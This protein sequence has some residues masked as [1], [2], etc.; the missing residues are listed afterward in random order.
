MAALV[1][2]YR[3]RVAPLAAKVLG[4]TEGGLT[5]AG[6]ELGRLAAEAERAFAGTD[7][8]VVSHGALRADIDPGP[9]TYGEV[10]EALAVR[11]PGG[12]RSS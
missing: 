10:A 2:G 5:R 7:A 12:A 4:H 1:E 3:R 6:G 8:A 9:I 11:P